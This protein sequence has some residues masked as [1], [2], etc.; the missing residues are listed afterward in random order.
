ML[1]YF[2]VILSFWTFASLADG[3]PDSPSEAYKQYVKMR[4]GYK[5]SNTKQ[6]SRTEQFEM[7]DY[8]FDMEKKFPD[9]FESKLMWHINDHYSSSDGSK[10]KAAYALAPKNKD[11]LK[12]MLS[13]YIVTGN[14]AKQQEFAIKVAGH[15]SKNELSYYQDVLPKS[16]VIIASS[17][18]DALPLYINQL[19]KGKGG[20]V[21]IVTMDYLINDV[22]RIS[23]ASKLGT[24]SMK[25]FG[26]EKAFIKKAMLSSSTVFV[27]STV[28]QAYLADNLSNSF[29][30]GLYYQS[31]ISKQE[32][33]LELFWKNVAAK[34]FASISLTRGERRLYR[35]YLPPLLTLY[36]FKLNAGKQDKVLRK[37]ITLIAEKVEQT[38]TV[39]E[40]LIDYES[41]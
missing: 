28:S 18:K 34:N 12:A 30:T 6:F 10:L 21:T 25:F 29:L 19:V 40:I 31:R 8:C 17:E 37:A 20:A 39:N 33:Q 27:S 23:M 11:V 14:K 32:S 26:S 16:G 3:L 7:D 15:Y 5:R 36:K 22:Y 35:N 4:E 24:G 2:I 1:R 13:Y 9:S 38:K 41:D